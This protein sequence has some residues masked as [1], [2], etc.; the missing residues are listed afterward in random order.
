[1][2]ENIFRL[3]VDK[4]RDTTK[5]CVSLGVCDGGRPETKKFGQISGRWHSEDLW[6]I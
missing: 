6:N 1:M 3:F 2:I 4:T 5:Q